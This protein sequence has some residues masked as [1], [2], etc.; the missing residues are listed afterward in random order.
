MCH[1]GF[2][3]PHLST[4]PLLFSPPSPPVT[5]HAIQMCTKTPAAKVSFMV[6]KDR[7]L[8]AIT[9]PLSCMS[10]TCTSPATVVTL[11]CNWLYNI[12]WRWSISGSAVELKSPGTCNAVGRE[13]RGTHFPDQCTGTHTISAVSSM[14]RC[15]WH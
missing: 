6:A 11:N 15:E 8:N 10:H 14:R 1:R 5:F 3:T 12:V 4:G 13:Q 7:A 2:G 9:G